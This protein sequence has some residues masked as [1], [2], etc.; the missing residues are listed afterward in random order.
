MQIATCMSVCGMVQSLKAHNAACSP[1][2]GSLCD[3]QG[4]CPICYRNLQQETAKRPAAHML[5]DF[6]R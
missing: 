6:D 3:N 2:R 4:H 1:C 5:I